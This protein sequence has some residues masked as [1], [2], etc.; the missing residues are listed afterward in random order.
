VPAAIASQPSN[1]S[2]LELSPAI[3]NVGATGI[4]VPVY[5]WYRGATPIL[6]GTNA[7][8]SLTSAAYTDNNAQF[9]VVVQNIVSN[10][11]HSV[12]S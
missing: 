3:F 1:Q 7:S 10:V 8:Y 9:R 5:Q 12:T 6:G 11:T 2:V 4:P